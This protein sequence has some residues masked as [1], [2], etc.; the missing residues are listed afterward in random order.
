MKVGTVSGLR[1]LIGA[2]CFVDAAAALRIV[3]RLPSR[4]R[5][6]LG[7]V[8]VDEVTTL[9]TCKIPNQRIVMLGGTTTMPP[10]PEQAR[11]LLRAD[12]RAFR[13]ALARAA[14]LIGT[15]WVFAQG[16]GELV[17]TAMRAATG[18]DV[19][20]IGYRPVNKVPGKIVVLQP[21]L[22]VS[23][24]LN[25]ASAQLSQ[26]L[27]ADRVVFSVGGDATRFKAAQSMDTVQFETLDTALTELTRTNA[28]AVLVDMTQGPVQDLSELARVL[29]VA[30]CPLLVFGLSSLN[31]TLEHSTQIPPV[32]DRA[33]RDGQS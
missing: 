3:E 27:S 18:W 22:H 5:A 13:N 15:D 11:T 28:Q 4:F 31:A 8:L 17:G 33:G 9:A 32:P 6:N 23:D 2:G 29:E 10:S 25:E 21:H 20:V 12:A 1:I 26:Q 19:L 14:E 7:G 16:R 24:M 30:R